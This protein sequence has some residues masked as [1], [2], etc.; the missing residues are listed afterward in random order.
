MTARCTTPLITKLLQK[1]T[2]VNPSGCWEWTGPTNPLGYG[3]INSGPTGRRSTHRASYAFFVGP[4]PEGLVLDH[5]C[6]NRRCAN[7]AHLEAVTCAENLRRGVGFAAT[8][9]RKTHC[10]NGHEFDDKNTI[11]RRDGR[12]CREC[13]NAQDRSRRLA[14]RTRE[15]AEAALKVLLEQP[16]G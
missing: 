16:Q 3:L 5:L 2:P 8:N 9:A 11:H 1:V 6:R 7:P 4:I 14:F 10:V 13:R 15:A 12:R